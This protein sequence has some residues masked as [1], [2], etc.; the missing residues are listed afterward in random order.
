MHVV[1]RLF[2]L[3]G[4]DTSFNALDFL[5]DCLAPDLVFLFD[6]RLPFHACLA[7]DFLF[8]FHNTSGQNINLS[9]G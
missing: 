5:N 6:L 8:N 9:K 7:L 4:S 1:A 2:S 3:L